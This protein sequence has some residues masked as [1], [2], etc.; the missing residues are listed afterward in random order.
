MRLKEHPIP[1]SVLKGRVNRDHDKLQTGVGILELPPKETL[2]GKATAFSAVQRKDGATD[3]PRRLGCHC[4]KEHGAANAIPLH[5]DGSNGGHAGQRHGQYRHGQYRAPLRRGR[6][7]A[8][9]RRGREAVLLALIEIVLNRELAETL[10]VLIKALLQEPAE[11]IPK[12]GRPTAKVLQPTPVGLDLRDP[13]DVLLL[14]L[15]LMLDTHHIRMVSPARC[16]KA[17]EHSATAARH[18]ELCKELLGQDRPHDLRVRE[19]PREEPQDVESLTVRSQLIDSTA[20]PNLAAV[21]NLVELAVTGQYSDLVDRAEA[22]VSCRELF[23]QQ[24]CPLP[25]GVQGPFGTLAQPT[26]QGLCGYVEFRGA[27]IPHPIAEP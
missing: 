1:Q 4:R 9:E 14:S 8:H 16:W 12:N 20:P 17:P 22:H 25:L 6:S 3:T 10:S 24:L 11:R 19:H 5:R 15:G 26:T 21:S 7:V 2:R 13:A 18:L 23:E 27:M